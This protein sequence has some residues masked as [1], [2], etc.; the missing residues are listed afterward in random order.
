MISSVGLDGS[1]YRQYKSG[2]GELVSFAHTE[3]LLVWATRLK[4]EA[5]VP[6]LSHRVASYFLSEAPPPLSVNLQT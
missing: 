1:G 5:A 4:G 6:S 3:N 2:P